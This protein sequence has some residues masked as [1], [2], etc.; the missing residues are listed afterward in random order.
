M[1]MMSYIDATVLHLQA[2]GCVRRCHRLQQLL[3]SKMTMLDNLQHVLHQI[4]MSETDAMV[5]S[6]V[7]MQCAK[8]TLV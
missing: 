2:V 6:I 8:T 3:S 5:T 4:Q 1:H 7:T